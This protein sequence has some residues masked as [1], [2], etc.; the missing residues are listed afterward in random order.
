MILKTLKRDWKRFEYKHT[1]LTI[2][3]MLLTV[4]ALNTALVT[5]VLEWFK[6]AGL[7]GGFIAGIMSVSMFTTAPALVLIAAI[8]QHSETWQLVAVASVGSVLG[9]WIII[10]FLEDEV[11]SELKPALKKYHIL[12]IIRRLQRSGSRWALSFIGAVVLALPLPDEFG[13][14]LM[15]ISHLKRRYL[16]FICFILNTIGIYFLALASKSLI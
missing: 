3:L 1:S 12:P 11:A 16:L 14:A 15:D 13:I 6:G 8:A 10:K 7:L 9:D 4:L 5:V 2:I